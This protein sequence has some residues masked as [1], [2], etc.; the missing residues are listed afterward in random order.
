MARFRRR[1]RFL[2]ETSE[3]SGFDN[4]DRSG[5]KRWESIRDKGTKIDPEEFD[6]PPPSDQSLG[7]ADITGTP[8][9]NDLTTDVPDVSQPTILH[10]TA[11][12]GITINQEPFLLI[13]GSTTAVNISADPQISRGR[14][15]QILGIQCVG[16][17]V[18]LDDGDGLE[19]TAGQ[20]FVMESGSVINFI[21][22]G[23]TNIW[24]EVSRGDRY[25]S[26]GMF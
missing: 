12:G 8:R 15:Q 26:L 25:K 1:S 7:G 21:Y 11:A 24:Q 3:R 6:A 13:T 18:T 22:N 14:P 19:L 4:F 16:S 10:I 20:S 17:N 9:T 23:T 5:N 2:K